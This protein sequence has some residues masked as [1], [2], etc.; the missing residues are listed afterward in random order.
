MNFPQMLGKIAVG[1]L[2]AF[3]D[4]VGVLEVFHKCSG[5]RRMKEEIAKEYVK[6]CTK[7]IRN[8][9]IVRTPGY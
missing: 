2:T 6:M 4:R 8:M 7:L 1:I 3:L 9:T 5:R